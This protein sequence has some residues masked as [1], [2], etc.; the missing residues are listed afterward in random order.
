M[1]SL[2]DELSNE[3]LDVDII[4]EEQFLE[5]DEGA[6]RAFRRVGN[7]I[8]Q[9]YRCTSGPKKGKLA[10]D[11]SKCGQRKDPAKVR[12]GRKV[13]QKK[14]AI[15]VRKTIAKKK[16]QVSKRVTQL[17]QTIRNRNRNTGTVKP[18]GANSV[19]RESFLDYVNTDLVMEQ[20]NIL[21][22]QEGYLIDQIDAAIELIENITVE[23]VVSLLSESGYNTSMDTIQDIGFT[24]DEDTTTLKLSMV[25]SEGSGTPATIKITKTHTGWKATV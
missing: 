24:I 1:M 10:S 14:G 18:K 25:V 6:Q 19:K 2:L 12:H 7:N 3:E 8:S 23:K 17:N 22:S 21:E 16:T 20:Y 15:R 13:A 4:S 11:P 5:L 9:Y